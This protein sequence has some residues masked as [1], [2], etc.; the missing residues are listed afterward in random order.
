MNVYKVTATIDSHKSV[1]RIVVAPSE[2]EA[3][4]SFC[5]QV[6]RYYHP[7]DPDVIAAYPHTAIEVDEDK[8]HENIWEVHFDSIDFTICIIA[9]SYVD[10][11]DKVDDACC[12][13]AV[14]PSLITRVVKV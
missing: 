5:Q 14:D 3:H 2:Q 12:D 9:S 7:Y 8:M 10:A 6:C 13:Y 1:S 4:R 11:V